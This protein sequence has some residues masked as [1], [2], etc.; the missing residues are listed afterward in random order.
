VVP[1][2]AAL[3]AA[4]SQRDTER[5]MSQNSTPV[6]KRDALDQALARV[7]ALTGLM[8]VAVSRL[9]P[10]S[11]LRKRL[12]GLAIRRGF[13]AMARSDV[14]LVLQRYE[15]DVEVWMRGMAAVGV[16][17][18][19]HGHEGIRDLYADVDDVFDDWRWILQGVVDGGDRLATR[20]DFVGRGRGSG[21]QTIVSDAGMA[22]SLSARG[23]IA[24]QEFFVEQNGWPKALEAAGLRE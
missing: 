3:A 23:R 19:Y 1:Q 7:P 11:M 22:I 5:P 20:M 6:P 14:E 21:V 24:W 10:G 18:C 2:A 17:D 13:A 8:I 16:S 15:P 4:A 12:L 9:H